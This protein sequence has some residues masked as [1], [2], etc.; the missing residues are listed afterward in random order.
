MSRPTT[1]SQNGFS[2]VEMLMTIVV[3]GLFA[4]TFYQL[5][6]TVHG[7]NSQSRQQALANDIAYSYLRKYAAVQAPS[8]TCNS[9]SDLTQNA[10]APGTVLESGTLTPADTGLPG[11]ISY[12]VVALAVYGCRGA[13]SQSPLKIE[14]S[15]QYGPRSKQIKHG[16]LV[17]Y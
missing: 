10:S 15:I 1:A 16:T 7:V 4:V 6:T 17:G 3:A 14:S 5:F 9:T 2:S 12:R 13:N 11:P 8:I